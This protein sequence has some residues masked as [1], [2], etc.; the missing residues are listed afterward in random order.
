M[1]GVTGPYAT[2]IFVKELGASEQSV[3]RSI[4]LPDFGGEHPD[5]NLTYAPEL[6]QAVRILLLSLLTFLSWLL[7]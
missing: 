2:R 4:P 7:F 5:P 3:V 1:N 6:V